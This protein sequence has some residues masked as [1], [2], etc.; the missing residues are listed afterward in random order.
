MIII[1]IIIINVAFI[2][3]LK[4]L[5]SMLNITRKRIQAVDN[6]N[7]LNHVLYKDDLKL[8]G[9]NEKEIESLLHTVRIFSTDIGMTFG[10]DKCTRLGVRRGNVV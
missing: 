5:T 4:P 3:C 9:K 7:V 10:I 1:I 6:G 2:I 8:Y